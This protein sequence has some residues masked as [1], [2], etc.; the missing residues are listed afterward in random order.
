MVQ[1]LWPIRVSRYKVGG[2]QVTSHSAQSFKMTT[3]SVSRYKPPP[4]IGI[5]QVAQSLIASTGAESGWCILR[6]M[7]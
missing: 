3:G 2:E 4:K 6:V 7:F 1:I 5:S